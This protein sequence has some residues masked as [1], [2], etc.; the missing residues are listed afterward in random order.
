VKSQRL[1]GLMTGIAFAAVMMGILFV[2]LDEKRDNEDQRLL[3][4]SA[5]AAEMRIRGADVFLREDLPEA[6]E[7]LP[8]EQV[9]KILAELVFDSIG[10]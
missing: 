2:V 7:D 10:Q 4:K 8:R 5:A 3:C 1:H 6:C 9:D